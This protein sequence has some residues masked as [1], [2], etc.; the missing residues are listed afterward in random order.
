M[1]SGYEMPG[2]RQYATYL[3]RLDMKEIERILTGSGMSEK[4]QIFTVGLDY[5]IQ[6]NGNII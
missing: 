1:I 2:I 5:R 3:C 6:Q 4:Y